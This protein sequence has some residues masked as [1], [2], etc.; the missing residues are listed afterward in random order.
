MKQVNTESGSAHVA[1]IVLL[2]LVLVC[3]LSFIFWQNVIQKPQN[4]TSGA[5]DKSASQILPN[6]SVE[7]LSSES[8]VTKLNFTSWGVATEIDSPDVSVGEYMNNDGFEY[9]EIV[10]KV[11]GC[12]PDV[13]NPVS[14]GRISRYEND[15][16]VQNNVAMGSN[17]TIV[18]EDYTYSFMVPQQACGD[19]QTIE[20]VAA[21]TKQEQLSYKFISALQSLK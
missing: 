4:G 1:I 21:N 7:S 15:A 8:N 2:V 13:E 6:G 3:A 5:D 11:D 19:P 14:I 20:G 9:Y 17:R 16:A 10:A 18:V 12:Y